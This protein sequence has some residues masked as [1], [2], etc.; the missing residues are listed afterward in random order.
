MKQRRA[1]SYKILF[2]LTEELRAQLPAIEMAADAV[3]ELDFINAKAVFHQKFNCVI[4]E[5]AP[6][7]NS[8][9]GIPEPRT[10]RQRFR[11]QQI[12]LN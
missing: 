1:K 8:S 2:G 7:V 6:V 5:I 10:T 3:A 4:P 12:L 9:A 11:A